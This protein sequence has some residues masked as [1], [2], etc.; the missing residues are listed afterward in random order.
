MRAIPKSLRD[1]LSDDPFMKKCVYTGETKDI[2]W[3]H[4]WSYAGKQINED[5]AIVPLARRL[6]TSHPPREVK[7]Y[8][9]WISINRATEEELEKYPRKDW[10]AIKIYLNQKFNN[11]QSCQ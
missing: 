8:C 9:R 3:E 11:Q 10:R 5:W 4:C 7:E 2:S 1:Q 6:N